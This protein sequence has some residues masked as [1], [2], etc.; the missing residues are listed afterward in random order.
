MLGSRSVAPAPFNPTTQLYPSDLQGSDTALCCLLLSHTPS[1]ICGYSCRCCLGRMGSCAHVCCACMRYSHGR[2]QP[3]NVW[4]SAAA[5]E[6]IV[7]PG[8][9]PLVPSSRA[10]AS[11]SRR[12]WMARLEATS[13]GARTCFT[14]SSF[15][16]GM[17]R[18]MAPEK[19]RGDRWPFAYIPLAC[20][21]RFCSDRTCT[22]TWRCSRPH[23][24]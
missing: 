15:T 4:A 19:L 7:A 17:G 12:C 20:H 6:A 14:R 22:V 8:W 2:R 18:R 21:S 24:G 11:R 23:L 16:P 5:Q 13:Q 10:R 9:T 3:R 1:L